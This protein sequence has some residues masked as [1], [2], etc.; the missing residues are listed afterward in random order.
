MKETNEK[1]R[2]LSVVFWR[3]LWSSILISLSAS[4]GTVVDGIIVG[5]LIGEDGVSAVNLSSPMI[6]LLF[7]ISL[8]VAS[9]AGMLIGFALGQKDGRRVRYIFTLSMVASLLVGVLFTGAGFYFS[10]S[11]TR[12][13]C[14]DDYLFTYTHDYLKVILIGAPSF[15]MLWEISAV[16]GVGGSPRLASFSLIL[17]NLVN[18]CL[19]I[20]FFEYF[21]WG[22]AGFS[23][24]TVVGHLVGILFL[25]RPFKG[26]GNSLTFSL[27]HDKPEFLNI[28]LQ[29]A[30]L[31]IASVCLTLLL[32]SAN[33]V[34]L[35]A[36]GQNGIFV[37]AVCMNLLQIY[38]MY[39]SGTCRTLQS[40]GAV[41]IGKNDDHAF[42]LILRKSFLFITVSMAVTCLLI[43]LFPGVIS[44]AFGADSPEVIAECNHVFR[45]FAVSFI[46]FCYIYL[47]MIVYKLYKQ[48][49]MALFISFALSLTVIPVLLLFF[50]Y[51]PQYL[52]YSYLVAY[53]L[54]IVAIFVLHKL[55][56]ARLSL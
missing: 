12:A 42:N 21:G 27:T 24:A 41:Q 51:A 23:S 33:H 49:R 19:G 37:F 7:T 9:G 36:K 32:V 6:Q 29:G 46:P 50:H 3:Y 18:L 30:P 45:I 2:E 47:I 56:H 16:I 5:N 55:T 15:M 10:D 20:F 54:E 1:D 31:A 43:C 22:I 17:D 39:I 4:V 35:S 11:I 34:F 44:R 53:L 14:H 48:D 25:L 38:N 28:V 40:L 52:W 26:K 8:V 13:F